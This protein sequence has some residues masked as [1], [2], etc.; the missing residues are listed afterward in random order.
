[1]AQQAFKKKD[2]SSQ[3]SIQSLA[4]SMNPVSSQ[5]DHWKDLDY[6]DDFIDEEE[7]YGGSKQQMKFTIKCFNFQVMISHQPI[8]EYMS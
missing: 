4:S 3:R 1:M 7:E 6:S 2:G 5:K 8:L